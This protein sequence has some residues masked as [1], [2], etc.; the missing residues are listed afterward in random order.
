MYRKLNSPSKIKTWLQNNLEYFSYEESLLHLYYHSK[1]SL[2][3]NTLSLNNKNSSSLN[4]F[5]EIHI[6]VL[7]LV[8]LALNNHMHTPELLVLNDKGRVR[9]G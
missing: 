4:T 1:E 2:T 6:D 5:R 8:L 3:L 7:F 9:L